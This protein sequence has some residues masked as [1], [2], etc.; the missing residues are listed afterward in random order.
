M[1][2]ER[3]SCGMLIKQINSELEKNANNALRSDNLTLSQIAVLSELDQVPEKQLS[4]KQMEKKVHVA[5]S[6]LAGVVKRLEKKGFVVGA[7]SE[8]DRRVKVI[9]ITPAGEQ[10]CRRA[11]KTAALHEQQLL[12][13]LTE[14]EKGTFLNLL[15]KIRG[16]F[17]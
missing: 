12:S 11:E 10:C 15:Q 16:S 3:N 7:E 4:M 6:T 1:I 17:H 5:Q 8:S 9:R 14:E 2:T 13:A